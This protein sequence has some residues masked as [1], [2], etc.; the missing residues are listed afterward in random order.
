[1]IILVTMEEAGEML[2]VALALRAILIYIERDLGVVALSVDWA[3]V[4][5]STQVDMTQTASNPS[6]L[7]RANPTH[8]RLDTM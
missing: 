2:A 3:P 4:M 6:A 8:V 7:S 1:M 5:P